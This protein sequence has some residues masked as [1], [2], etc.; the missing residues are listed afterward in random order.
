MIL[1]NTLAALAAAFAL[2]VASAPPAAA[3]GDPAIAT[4]EF[5][6]ASGH[7]T[8]GGVEIRRE[9]GA[10]WI[11]LTESFDFDGA[12]D[13]RVGFGKGGTFAEGTDFAPLK[14]NSGEQRY[15]VPDGLDPADYTEVFIWCRQF[16]VPL[17][18][19]TL[20]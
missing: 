15:R 2:F 12:P 20:G 9:D 14:A 11:V 19:A 8:T 16:S 17:G 3:D 13:P 7:V 1:R 5:R 6:G 18:Y 4:G 10:W